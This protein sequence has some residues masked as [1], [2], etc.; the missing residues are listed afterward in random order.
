MG[1]PARGL[2]AEP[3]IRQ[4][5]ESGKSMEDILSSIRQIIA[6]EH[7]NAEARPDP[8][9]HAERS[10]VAAKANA[11]EQTLTSGRTGSS[12]SGLAQR[13]RTHE[14]RP[15]SRSLAQ[16]PTH[17]PA[18][19]PFQGNAHDDSRLGRTE[20][21]V[22]NPAK[23]PVAASRPMA[24]SPSQTPG[25]LAALA[26]KMRS[27]RLGLREQSMSSA[28]SDMARDTYHY[29]SAIE[30]ARIPMA[31]G[32]ADVVTV[33]IAPE[34]KTETKTAAETVTGRGTGTGNRVSGEGTER[35]SMSFSEIAALAKKEGPNGESAPSVPPTRI[36]EESQAPKTVAAANPI[37]AGDAIAPFVERRGEES[38]T[39]Q[40]TE[41][42]S[43]TRHLET[44]ETETSNLQHGET[45]TLAAKADTADAFREAL[46]SPA[47]KAA[48]SDSMQRLKKCV[49]DIDSARVESVLRPMLKEWLDENL[50][51]MVERMVRQ[52][53]D[54]VAGRSEG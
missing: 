41:S 8:G 43:S 23:V 54:A 40:Q 50:P 48:V 44:D 20:E 26:A 49:E 34:A 17:N 52:E 28:H 45:P 36:F 53:I 22:A 11:Q 24:E 42:L 4:T 7:V 10:D 37:P 38:S 27:E 33:T 46:V 29:T 30:E 15:T 3:A 21:T 9:D 32:P 13:L 2:A 51:G 5:G 35:N 1:E 25:G 6:R 47:T 31:S 14:E 18:R 39:G 19:D 16:S 12:L